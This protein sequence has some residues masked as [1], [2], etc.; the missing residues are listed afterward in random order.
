MI[1]PEAIRERALSWLKSARQNIVTAE[2]ARREGAIEKSYRYH[3][4]A[5]GEVCCAA[6]LL[7][8]LLNERTYL[9]ADVEHAALDAVGL[10]IGS[11]H[12]CKA[13]IARRA[14]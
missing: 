1:A 10:L 7:D 11:R 8:A 6:D 14:A 5:L 9:F 12:T 3:A 13:C 4:L 2:R